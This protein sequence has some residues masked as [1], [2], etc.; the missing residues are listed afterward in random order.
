MF[1]VVEQVVISL[2]LKKL[3]VCSIEHLSFQNFTYLSVSVEAFIC[4]IWAVHVFFNLVADMI[5]Y[6]VARRANIALNFAIETKYQFQFARTASSQFTRAEGEDA[7]LKVCTNPE[8]SREN[9][10]ERRI[11][12]S[13]SMQILISELIHS[14]ALRNQKGIEKLI[15]Q[16]PGISLFIHQPI[17]S[18]IHPSIQPLSHS[19]MH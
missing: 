16:T 6:L 15:T 18:P 2:T 9:V 10:E 12:V 5:R 13:P 3:T 1:L 4:D 17:S 11:A 7:S 8:E 14:S 19:F